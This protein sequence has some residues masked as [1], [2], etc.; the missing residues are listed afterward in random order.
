MTQPSE[1][2]EWLDELV[3][4][5]TEVYKKSMTTLV[6]LEVVEE[7]VVDTHGVV[8]ELG[9]VALGRAHAAVRRRAAPSPALAGGY[10]RERS[11]DYRGIDGAIPG[12]G[13]ECGQRMHLM[14][15]CID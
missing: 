10:S 13:Q 6:L 12:P 15:S 14:A 8:E 5:W 11:P 7:G 1:S 3:Q 4:R 9:V 2:E